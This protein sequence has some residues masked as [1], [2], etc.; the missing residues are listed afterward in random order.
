MAH[1][2]GELAVMK[3]IKQE[4][5]RVVVSFPMI[6]FRE[7]MTLRPG[8]KVVLVDDDKGLG[9]KPLTREILVQQIAEAP[10]TVTADGR[11]FAVQESTI[12]DHEGR[13]GPYVITIVDRDEAAEGPE[14]VIAIRSVG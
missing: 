9:V 12:R 6:G 4:G 3:V 8:E 14:Q 7:G 5:R 10:G 2:T 13:P 1:A 11:R